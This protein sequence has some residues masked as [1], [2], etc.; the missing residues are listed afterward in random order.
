[1]DVMS[2]HVSSKLHKICTRGAKGKVLTFAEIERA[3]VTFI[4]DAL[5]LPPALSNSTFL[6]VP[7][8][9]PF[10]P[11]VFGE[12]LEFIMEQQASITDL[13]IP[14]IVPFLA[15]MVLELNGLSSEGIFRVPGDADDV[16]ELVRKF[17]F[18]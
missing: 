14:K 7:Q 3:K 4:L 10:K 1:M 6:L 11:S 5:S 2:Q 9:A 13:D 8:D 17:L 16:T 18:D 12:T 15:N